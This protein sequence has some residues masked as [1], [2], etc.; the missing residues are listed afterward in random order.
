MRDCIYY[1]DQSGYIKPY[2]GDNLY[3]L[4]AYYIQ[5]IKLVG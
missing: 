1:N 3:N 5:A 2:L 4:W